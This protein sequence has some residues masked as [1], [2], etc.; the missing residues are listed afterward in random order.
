MAA[1]RFSKKEIKPTKI[2][3]LS[4]LR[5]SV[6]LTVRMLRFEYTDGIPTKILYCDVASMDVYQVW[7]KSET[8]QGHFYINICMTL[9]T[10][11]ERNSPFDPS[12]PLSVHCTTFNPSH[13][14]GVSAAPGVNAFK[15]KINLKA[16]HCCQ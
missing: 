1:T 7:L 4:L 13:A 8:S 16:L 14:G 9:C 5:L 15:A 11:V 10:H 2:P 3:R 12:M 6:G